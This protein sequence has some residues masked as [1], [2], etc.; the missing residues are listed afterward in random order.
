MYLGCHARVSTLWLWSF[1]VAQTTVSCVM[2]QELASLV[3]TTWVTWRHARAPVWTCIDFVFNVTSRNIF[4]FFVLHL[5]LILMYNMP[6]Y[7]EYQQFDG[8]IQYFPNRWP[9][10]E[11]KRVEKRHQ[12]RRPLIRAHVVD[13]ER[14]TPARWSQDG[15][16]AVDQRRNLSSTKWV[17]A[18][19]WIMKRYNVM[20]EMT[21]ILKR[22]NRSRLKIGGKLIQQT[23]TSSSPNTEE[24]AASP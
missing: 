9:A 11:S 6:Q 2:K 4:T 13:N 24:P 8:H 19:F 22:S 17:T 5:L 18:P 20:H 1:P 14:A 7:F 16:R 15:G 23:V 10:D 3:V 21:W 12:N